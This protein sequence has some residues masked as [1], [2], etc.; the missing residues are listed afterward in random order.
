MR[1]TITVALTIGVIGL[2]AARADAS[3]RT[4]CSETRTGTVCAKVVKHEA[5]HP[6]RV[7]ATRLATHH[8]LPMDEQ[9]RVVYLGWSTKNLQDGDSRWS[10]KSKIQ[11]NRYHLYVITVR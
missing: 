11:A 2:G 4:V 5:G 9:T 3:Y 10:V 8:N 7:E 6:Q 1:K